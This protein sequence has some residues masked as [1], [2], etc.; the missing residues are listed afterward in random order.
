MMTLRCDKLKE[1]IDIYETNI[2]FEEVVLK[3]RDT[4]KLNMFI[5]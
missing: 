5:K 1:V 3:N 2:A 4:E